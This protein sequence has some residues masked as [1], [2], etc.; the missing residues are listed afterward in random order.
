MGVIVKLWWWF[1]ICLIWLVDIV[2]R[3][4]VFIW[5]MLKKLKDEH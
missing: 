3:I 5:V 2:E 1:I 4:I